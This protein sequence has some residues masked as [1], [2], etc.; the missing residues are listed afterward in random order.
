MRFW[1]DFGAHFGTIL[2]YFWP[3]GAPG[4]PPG[5]PLSHT[6]ERA[7]S[8]TRFVLPCGMLPSTLVYFFAELSRY[9]FLLVHASA[10]S[11]SLGY[12]NPHPTPKG[13]WGG[14]NGSSRAQGPLRA[15]WGWTALRAAHKVF[16]GLSWETFSR[17]AVRMRNAELPDLARLVPN[18]L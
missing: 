15:P 8:Q 10:V 9:L 1:G 2:V 7:P 14:P 13:P 4:D 18:I 16:F 5:Q 3:L 12:H 11:R 6:S 17:S